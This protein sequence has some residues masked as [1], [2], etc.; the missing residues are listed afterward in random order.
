[1]QSPRLHSLRWVALVAATLAVGCA[2][3][4]PTVKPSPVD[5]QVI[6]QSRSAL[7]TSLKDTRNTAIKVKDQSSAT[8][9][10]LDRLVDPKQTDLKSAY[11]SFAKAVAALDSEAAT[12]KTMAGKVSSDGQKFLSSW[13]QDLGSYANK[14]VKEEGA[15]R[16]KEVVES[17]TDTQSNLD[18]TLGSVSELQVLLGDVKK[19]LGNALS[20]E[21]VEQISSVAGDARKSSEKLAKLI[22]STAESID[23]LVNELPS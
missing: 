16:H 20:P 7:T 3:E 10:A 5:P 23:S 12:M 9:T 11:D 14:D 2:T 15:S 6:A 4:E 13:Q 19:Y 18:K 8:I 22:D 17:F 21:G 1:M